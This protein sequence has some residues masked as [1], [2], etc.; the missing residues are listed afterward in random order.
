VEWRGNLDLAL[1][2]FPSEKRGAEARNSATV[3]EAVQTRRLFAFTILNSFVLLCL[4][5]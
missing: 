5:C 1:D 2:L 4:D 3:D